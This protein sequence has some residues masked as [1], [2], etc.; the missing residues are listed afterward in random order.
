MIKSCDFCSK[1]IGLFSPQA[2]ETLKD[3]L[4]LCKKCYASLW[5]KQADSASQV[6]NLA[7]IAL[8]GGL[9][10]EI[11]QIVVKRVKELMPSETKAPDGIV[12]S[13][14]SIENST[15]DESLS[16]EEKADQVEPSY[17]EETGNETAQ[18]STAA[19]LSEPT[20]AMVNEGSDPFEPSEKQDDTDA[21]P[22][23]SGKQDTE[24]EPIIIS[25]EKLCA[26]DKALYG[27]VKTLWK[28]LGHPDLEPVTTEEKSLYEQI[29]DLDENERYCHLTLDAEIDAFMYFRRLLNRSNG[30]KEMIILPLSVTKTRDSGK[31]FFLKPDDIITLVQYQH[32][33]IN[34]VQAVKK[35]PS[36]LD[37]TFKKTGAKDFDMFSRDMIFRSVQVRIFTE[38][39]LELI[40]VI[41]TEQDELGRIA[42]IRYNE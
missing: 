21:T 32:E 37:S 10:P 28:S 23:D 1:K 4:C 12:D 13:V 17:V 25:Y 38:S 29:K 3:G 42:N 33:S 8:S 9:R 15:I 40:G 16:V 14:E 22:G 18:D 11:K 39:I 7:K 6:K 34:L 24:G 41:V 20:P 27:Q 5:A 30:I 31:E 36:I 19:E 26:I 35:D 2:N